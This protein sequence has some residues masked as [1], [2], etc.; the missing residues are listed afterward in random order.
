MRFDFD[1]DEV[2]GYYVNLL[3]TISLRLNED[4]VQFFFR[5]SQDSDNGTQ[6]LSSPPS[7]PLYTEA[8]KFVSHRDGMVRAAVKTL[9]LNVFAIELPS[10]RQFLA[11]PPPPTAANAL[12]SLFDHLA[13]YTADRCFALDT[14]LS[15]WD[16]VPSRMAAMVET[17]LAEIEDVLTFCN[18]VLAV[19][20]PTM[21]ARLLLQLW[22]R[23]IGPILIYPL[24]L[25]VLLGGEEPVAAAA[26]AAAV[27]NRTNSK[28]EDDEHNKGQQRSHVGP[29]CSL[30]ALERIMYA[31]T[32]PLLSDFLVAVVL[33]G[34]IAEAATALC[35]SLDQT[36]IT[37]QHLLLVGTSSTTTNSSNG[38][39][40]GSKEMALPSTGCRLALLNNILLRNSNNSSRSSSSTK[41]EID[42]HQF[43]QLS[44]A[45][46][47]LIASIVAKR[48]VSEEMAEAVG[49]LPRRRQLQR[50]LIEQL[51][52]ESSDVVVSNGT[53]A[54]TETMETNKK[55]EDL[56]TSFSLPHLTHSQESTPFASPSKGGDTRAPDD[57]PPSSPPSTGAVAQS[58]PTATST[59]CSEEYFDEI[60]TA[61]LSTASCHPQHPPSS[62]NGGGG[63][64]LL[65]PL[66]F[67]VIAWALHRLLSSDS[68]QQRQLLLREEW[69]HAVDG[70]VHTTANAVLRQALQGSWRD[71]VGAGMEVVWV[72]TRDV[73]LKSGSG[74][75]HAASHTW[76]Q[77]ILVNELHWQL[78]GGGTGG[79]GKEA[80][81]AAAVAASSF[82]IS[83]KIMAVNVATAVAM[84]QLHQV[85][86]F[87]DISPSF[88]TSLQPPPPMN[89]QTITAMELKE[90]SSVPLPPREEC[91]PCRVAFSRG[92][93]KQVVAT[94]LLSHHGGCV[95]P[96]VVILEPGLGPTE[97]YGTVLSSAPLVAAAPAV[98]ATHAQWLHVH[99]RQPTPTLLKIM[100]S[101]SSSLSGTDLAEMDRQL[102]EGHWVLAFNS[103][104]ESAQA[105]ERIG[106]LAE[107]VKKECEEK[108]LSDFEKSLV[109]QW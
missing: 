49:V 10:L 62:V 106:R 105:A 104:E 52:R 27:S 3:K 17:C 2:L 43:A 7:F 56:L 107:S 74:G 94:V 93:E 48:T 24:L 28:T 54:A 72:R 88:T 46:V 19:G 57:S 16:E 39:D 92:I 70:M 45:T 4:T 42:A 55:K 8:I 86:T 65:P 36:I 22:D 75:V 40:T 69:K 91:M 80:A 64:L 103:G 87:G 32:D 99:V 108:V 71:G 68:A 1:D 90:G 83:G 26:A 60:I 11:S 109:R 51:T 53:V 30:Y 61:L 50:Q 67:P 59:R 13:T 77:G 34:S 78:G 84:I 29:L 6:L 18:D 63:G 9:A 98:D 33:G 15:S 96:L 23:V 82:S 20:I 66:V 79:G 41:I 38:D 44:A 14:L 12:P 81:T 101:S 97:G 73:I 25:L 95:P 5:A 37:P 21:S 35:E 102:A 76:V 58:L 100:M 85:L 89:I 47:R 31:V